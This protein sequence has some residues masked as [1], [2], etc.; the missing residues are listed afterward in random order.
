M[1]VLTR[2]QG[3]LTKTLTGVADHDVVESAGSTSST[4][5]VHTNPATW[6]TRNIE[7]S[8]LG[9]SESAMPNSEASDRAEARREAAPG[10]RWSPC[11]CS[12]C[13]RS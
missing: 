5:R 7:G 4:A 10:Q 9:L 12:S 8:A 1:H 13:L 11:L 6:L 2:V 3:H